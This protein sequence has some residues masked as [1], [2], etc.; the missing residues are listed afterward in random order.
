MHGSTISGVIM[1]R[2]MGIGDWV[3]IVFALFALT[4]VLAAAYTRPMGPLV[5][6]VESEGG[7]FLYP[8]DE[9]R[10]LEV[11]GPLGPEKVIIRNGAVWIEEAPCPDKLCIA[12]GRIS[13]PGQ[14]IACLPNRIFVMV[15]GRKGSSPVDGTTF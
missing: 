5:V 13:S 2:S 4:G 12:M 1:R 14:W 8:L 15:E 7:V 3:I 9:D 11:E 10:T 6:R